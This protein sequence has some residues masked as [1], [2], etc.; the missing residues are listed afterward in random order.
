[1][2]TGPYANQEALEGTASTAPTT[3]TLARPS[4]HVEIIND[5][6]RTLQYRFNS[7]EN[8]ASLRGDEAVSM[9]IWIKQIQLR[10]LNNQANYRIRVVG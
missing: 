8:W 2:A 7:S 5:S 10:T 6:N 9:E 1:M 4:R 3:L